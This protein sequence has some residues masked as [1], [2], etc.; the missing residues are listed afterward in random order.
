[1]PFVHRMPPDFRFSV[2]EALHL[3]A[4]ELPTS[5]RNVDDDQSALTTAGDPTTTTSP[6]PQSNTD[7]TNPTNP[8]SS[9]NRSRSRRNRNTATERSALYIRNSRRGVWVLN[10]LL[11]C[12]ILAYIAC[13]LV[14]DFSEIYHFIFFFGILFE[15]AVLARWRQIRGLGSAQEILD[16][17][18]TSIRTSARRA[19]A[20]RRAADEEMGISNGISL[21]T[22]RPEAGLDEQC[23]PDIEMP[24]PTYI[25]GLTN[26]QCREELR[27]QSP[28]QVAIPV[29]EERVEGE[30]DASTAEQVTAELPPGYWSAI[31]GLTESRNDN[32][33]AQSSSTDNPTAT[34]VNM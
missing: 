19:A 29:A 14:A 24:P 13:Y 9:R 11:A 32:D 12:T 3:Q 10:A 28:A 2:R 25:V 21:P 31:A 1:M 17:V 27:V 22:Y 33:E 20:R 16:N 15:V 7:R 5:P 34:V 26:L 4:P 8:R 23:F 18:P 6:P 30:G